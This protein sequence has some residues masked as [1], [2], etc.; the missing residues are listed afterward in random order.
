MR[1]AVVTSHPIQ[2]YAPLF[3]HLATRVDLQV[4]FAHR[5]TGR[6]QAQ[7]GFNQAFEWDVD[8]LSGYP[9]TFLNNVSR[10]PSLDAFGGCDTPEVGERLRAGR[11][12]ALLVLGWYL[13]T[14][15]Q[16]IVAAKRAGIPVMVRGDSQLSTPAGAAKR[17]VKRVIYPV[18]LRA[19]DALLYVG[20]RSRE[21]YEHYGVPRAR[22]AFSPHC[23]DTHWFADRSGEPERRGLRE[24]H[25][26][27]P[28]ERV[29]LF[30]G[31]L[32]DRK[33]PLD[34]IAAASLLG[35]EGSPVSVM[36]A[37]S[38]P[39]EAAMAA[40]AREGDVR[41]IPLGFRNQTAM[42]ACYAAADL[43]ALPS[44]GQETWGLVANEALACG[45]PI[46]VSDAVGCA[47]DLAADGT[48]G[49]VFPLG[50]PQALARSI[51]SI[52]DTP[53]NARAISAKSD[54]YSI[55]AASDGVL[56]GLERVSRR[57]R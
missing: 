22:L 17:V 20:Q 16:A 1:L 19:F 34:L 11:F 27:R 24:A 8:L 4:F 53:P 3:R 30:A 28:D 13:K 12:D 44:N 39:L 9:N 26:I 32:L 40:A 7:A 47:P 15:V 55:A 14:F 10:T 56:T 23:V 36:V 2:Y 50:D 57:S 33:R 21:Y 43:L 46:V 37:G 29:V 54:A 52:F 35:R 5:P 6:D 48:A 41:L 31:K 51:R 25:D 18:A 42:P 49:R 45:R 38:G